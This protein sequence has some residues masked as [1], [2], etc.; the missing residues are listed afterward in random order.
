MSPTQWRLQQL[1]PRPMRRPQSWMRSSMGKPKALEKLKALEKELQG[2]KGDLD[3][4]RA[5]N[6]EV[7]NFLSMARAARKKIEKDLGLELNATPIKAR[8]TIA[9]YKELPSFNSGMEKMDRVSYEFGY[10]IV[11]TCF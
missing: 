11:L 1:K 4:G 8:A 3:I 10:K 2:L 5:K 7:E 9:Q 6:R